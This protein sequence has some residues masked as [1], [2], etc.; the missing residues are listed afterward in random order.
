L[1]LCL[2]ACAFKKVIQLDART[3]LQTLIALVQ[4]PVADLV[5]Y[6][7]DALMP[8]ESVIHADDPIIY[9]ECSHRVLIPTLKSAGFT[10]EPENAFC[11]YLDRYRQAVREVES[12]CE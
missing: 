9:R 12:L 5:R 2:G 8:I 3:Q 6:G 10:T 1:F 4:Y 11:N 7:E